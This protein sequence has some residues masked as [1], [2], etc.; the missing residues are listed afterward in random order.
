MKLI[1][2]QTRGKTQ[3]M[4]EEAANKSQEHGQWKL[5]VKGALTN[6]HRAIK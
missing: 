3:S 2:E 4:E 1:Q 6:Y 5:E